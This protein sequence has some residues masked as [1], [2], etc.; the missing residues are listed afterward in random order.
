M[1]TAHEFVARHAMHAGTLIL[2]YWRDSWWEWAT[3][4]WREVERRF[5]SER[6]AGKPA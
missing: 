4:R 3:T 6:R 2:R 1:Q 5:V